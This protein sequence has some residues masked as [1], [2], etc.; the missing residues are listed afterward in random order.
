M[1]L[2]RKT[3]KKILFPADLEHLDVR[4]SYGNAAVYKAMARNLSNVKWLGLCDA[5]VLALKNEPTLPLIVSRLEKLEKLDLSH[6]RL[7]KD[8]FIELFNICHKLK[9]L[10][11][12]K[13]LHIC[14]EFLPSMISR[15]SCLETLILDGTSVDDDCLNKVD[16]ISSKIKYLEIY[17]L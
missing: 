10:N 2:K 6:C 15:L 8:T 12:R 9:V 14:G 13:C 5:F 16:W 1:T 4:Y 17:R 7:A 11:L 3:I